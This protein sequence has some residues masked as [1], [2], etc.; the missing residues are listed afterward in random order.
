MID[1][2]YC[3]PGSL[4]EAISALRNGRKA[5]RVLAG[6]TDLIVQMKAGQVSPAVVM[7]IKKVPELNRLESDGDDTLHIGA[8]VPLSR[9]IAFPPV[10]E[11]FAMLHQACSLIGSVRI[12][13]RATM[14]GN[15]CN[16]A[17][18]ADSASPLLCLGARAI[19]TGLKGKT[20]AVP[21][22]SFFV[23]PGQTIL[24][25]DEL[26]VEVEI[27]APP[28]ASAGVY[29][30]HTPREEMDIAVVGGAS[31]LVMDTWEK[32]CREARI[33]LG[34]VA[35]TPV[36][37]PEAET[38]LQGKE[39]SDDVIEEASVIAAGAAS[40]ISDMRGSAE[41]RREL[42]KVLVRRTLREAWRILD[43]RN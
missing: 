27:P 2:E 38:F 24:A 7:D 35:P 1:F 34:A 18:S 37:A 26:L 41:Y 13:N 42:V 22:E 6:G 16:A 29:L 31:F 28:A 39:L 15:I 36:R 25:D 30:R 14:G 9:I 12:R 19:I 43:I 40:P 33:A 8:V 4:E 5:T 17:P 32:Q 20:R 3:V 21:L 11:K 10:M 23:G